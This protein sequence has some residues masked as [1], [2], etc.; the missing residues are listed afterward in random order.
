M[1]DYDK[2]VVRV[3]AD[4]AGVSLW[5]ALQCKVGPRLLEGREERGFSRDCN[6]IGRELQVANGPSG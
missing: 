1:P 4:V 3:P 5:V 6:V 2:D